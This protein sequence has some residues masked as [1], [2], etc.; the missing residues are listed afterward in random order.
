M[1]RIGVLSVLIVYYFVLLNGE[2]SSFN[3]SPNFLVGKSGSVYKNLSSYLRFENSADDT[4]E[5]KIDPLLID[6]K[7]EIIGLDSFKSTNEC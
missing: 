1:L 3:P 5:A 7:W 2:F 6:S 4:C